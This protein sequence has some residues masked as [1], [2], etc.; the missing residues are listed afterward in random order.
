MK[1]E[2]F[3]VIQ[4]IWIGKAAIFISFQLTFVQNL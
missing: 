4:I 1:G 3:E 2:I